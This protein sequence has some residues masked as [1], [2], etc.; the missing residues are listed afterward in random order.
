MKETLTRRIALAIEIRL[1][2]WELL[3]DRLG[4]REVEFGDGERER[5]AGDEAPSLVFRE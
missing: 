2:L 1:L 3:L 5:D 4:I